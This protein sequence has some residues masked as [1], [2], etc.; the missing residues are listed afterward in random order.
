MHSSSYQWIVHPYAEQILRSSK[1]AAGQEVTSQCRCLL[2]WWRVR[3]ATVWFLGSGLHTVRRRYILSMKCQFYQEWC[4][5]LRQHHLKLLFIVLYF[6][7]DRRIVGGIFWNVNATPIDP[8]TKDE[9]FF[10]LFLESFWAS[11][12]G[13][14]QLRVTWNVCGPQV[15]STNEFGDGPVSN[16][17]ALLCEKF[18]RGGRVMEG[19]TGLQKV[20]WVQDWFNLR[21]GCFQI[22][23]NSK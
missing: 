16:P 2:L 18:Q 19:A 3:V 20:Q 1:I 15:F 17:S 10:I 7:E 13:G 4:H 22:K 8:L 5:D 9:P 11:I 12:F 14:S 21:F 6:G 23:M